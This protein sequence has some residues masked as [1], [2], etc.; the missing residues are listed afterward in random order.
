MQCRLCSHR[1]AKYNGLCWRCRYI[2]EK[3]EAL[4]VRPKAVKSSKPPCVHC[5]ERAGTHGRGLCHKCHADTS[6]R[7]QYRN[8]NEDHDG[9]N[10][11]MAELDAM[12]AEQY[13]TMPRSRRDREEC[14]QAG[15]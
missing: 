6:I 5:G 1:R 9:D 10:L 4:P 2:P 14:E 15:L 12:V 11:T 7:E 13:P 3:A 8:A